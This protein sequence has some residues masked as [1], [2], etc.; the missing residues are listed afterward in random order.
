MTDK[1]Q[2]IQAR[3]ITIFLV[4]YLIYSFAFVLNRTSPSYLIL[5]GNELLCFLGVALVTFSLL[6]SIRT[7]NTVNGYVKMII[8]LLIIW[9]Y[10]LVAWSFPPDFDFFKAK[11]FI[12]ESSLMTYF[13]PLVVLIP[14]KLFFIKRAFKAVVFLGVLYFLFIFLFKDN[15]FKFY[16]NSVDNER[17]LFEYCAK[18]LSLCGGFLILT[19]EYHSKKVRVFAVVLVLSM[20][21]VAVFRARRAIMFMSI[22][23]IIMAAIIYVSKSRY[24]LIAIIASILIGIGVSFFALQA[25][26]NNQGGLFGNL[27]SRIDQDSRSGVEDCFVNDFTF[28]DWI[29]GRGFEG[30]YFCP[31]VDNNNAVVGY[32]TMIETDYLMIILKNGSVYLILLLLVLIPAVFKGIFQSKNILSKAAA[33]WILFWIICLYPANVFGFSMNYLLVWL[34]IGVCYSKEI[35]NI[36]DAVL[37]SYFLNDEINIE[38]VN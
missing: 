11:L 38:S 32:R 17:Y 23:P 37:K 25:Y 10:G 31:N 7:K 34:S 28:K 27:E 8:A 12:G 3:N 4:G 33:C 24:K 6:A 13:V 9:F 1:Y 26:E 5:I 30:K 20:L 22:L 14:N 35:R 15:I 36:P 19:F 29:V 16:G 21:L 2:Y 18:W